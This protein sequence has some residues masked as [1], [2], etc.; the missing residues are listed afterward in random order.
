MDFV[1]HKQWYCAHKFWAHHMAER[2]RF[3]RMV[4]EQRRAGNI[5]LVRDYMARYREHKSMS[6]Y[7]LEREQQLGK[8]IYKAETYD[9]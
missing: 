1:K 5:V 6:E 8:L 2:R 7:W 9:K 3:M 4:N